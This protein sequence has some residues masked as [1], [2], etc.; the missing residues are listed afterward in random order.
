[1]AF[2]V[3]RLND[4]LNAVG[5][6]FVKDLFSDFSCP[7]NEDVESFLKEKAILFQGMDVSRTY[8]VFTSYKGENVFVGYFA[9]ALK[10]LP[11]RKGVSP[12]QRKKLTGTKSAGVTF[13]PAILIGQLGKN[14]S[15]GYNKLITG[16][17][18]LGLALRK[19]LEIHQD[20]AGKV[21]FLECVDDRKLCE[22][23]EACGFQAYGINP[24]GLRQFIR[25]T[26]N[27]TLE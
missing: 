3:I 24:D 13:I 11:I 6:E 17:E 21:I 16:R 9:L 8:L 5:E 26:K 22:F 19:V 14:F 25:Y 23:Y 20:I 15:C 4:M 1:M 10:I 12:T 27:I 2:T 18:L 7:V